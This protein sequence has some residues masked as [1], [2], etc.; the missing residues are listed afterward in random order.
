MK[1]NLCFQ[2]WVNGAELTHICDEDFNRREIS[3]MKVTPQDV[4]ANLA[5]G[6]WTMALSDVLGQSTKEE[7]ELSDFELSCKSDDWKCSKCG[8]TQVI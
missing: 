5:T 6:V 8:T 7:I 3:E 1:I 4:L 2:G